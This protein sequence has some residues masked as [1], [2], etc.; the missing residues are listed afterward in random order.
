MVSHGKQPVGWTN[1]T[2]SLPGTGDRKKVST[3]AD[4]DFELG[5]VK[6]G[7]YRSLLV[8]KVVSSS[9][10]SWNA[11]GKNLRGRCG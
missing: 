7:A 6:E 1:R 11:G 9:L 10:M 8:H 2:E 3:D 5:V 4:G